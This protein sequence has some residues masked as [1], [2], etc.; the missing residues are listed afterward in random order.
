M[1]LIVE[2]G[3]IVIG[4]NSYVSIAEIR[5]YCEGRGIELPADNAEVEVM[6]VQAFDYVESF[7]SRYKGQT[8][9]DNQRTAWP[10]TGVVIDCYSLPS[11]EIPWQLKEAQ[12]QATGEAMEVDLMPNSSAAVKREKVDVLE[13]EYQDSVADG[14]P[15]NFPKVDAKL[16]MLLASSGY[17]VRVVRA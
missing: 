8:T 5:A 7:R 1:A 13:V 14:V 15:P 12:C 3:S 6:A 10:R 2:D 9:T 11:N 17:R 4:A 16:S